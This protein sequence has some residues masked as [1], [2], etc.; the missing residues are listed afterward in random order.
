MTDQTP[1]RQ[2]FTPMAPHLFT[3]EAT[4]MPLAK[5]PMNPRVSTQVRATDRADEIIQAVWGNDPTAVLVDYKLVPD[6]AGR[7]DEAAAEY[8]RRAGMDD[9]HYNTY[10]TDYDPND[11]AE[12]G[13]VSIWRV[14][15]RHVDVVRDR[16][17]DTAT[18]DRSMSPAE[19]SVSLLQHT[20]DMLDHSTCSCI[21]Y[22][23]LGCSV[24]IAKA[25]GGTTRL[26]PVNRAPLILLFRCCSACEELAGQI[27]AN[28]YKR[29]VVEARADLPPGG[30]IMP[31]PERPTDPDDPQYGAWA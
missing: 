16:W 11:L 23:D 17:H 19:E 14:G 10:D 30:K 2:G 31:N 1:Q 24:N 15:S 20:R 22:C 9:L 5:P 25:C 18:R 12:Q 6:L 7:A 13:V 4:T 26:L 21:N 28:A 8:H 3:P 27:A 29:H